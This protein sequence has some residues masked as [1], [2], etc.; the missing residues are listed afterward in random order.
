MDLGNRLF[1]DKYVRLGFIVGGVAGF[2][3]SHFIFQ[4]EI[5]STLSGAFVGWGFGAYW[6]YYRTHKGPRLKVYSGG[7]KNYW[8]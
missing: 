3:L 8:N 6:N 7:K 1:Q 4:Q 5:L 2:F